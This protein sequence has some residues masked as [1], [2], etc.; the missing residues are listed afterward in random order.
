M[1]KMSKR[2]HLIEGTSF[3][4][5]PFQVAESNV[6]RRMPKQHKRPFWDHLMNDPVEGEKID[7]RG[8]AL[9]GCCSFYSQ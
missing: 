4:V 6:G 2:V 3:C 7:D 8:L 5:K 1:K 9:S